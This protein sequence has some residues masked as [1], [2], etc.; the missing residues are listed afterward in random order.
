MRK[1][2]VGWVAVAAWVLAGTGAVQAHPPGAGAGLT[3]PPYVHPDWPRP[4][5]RPPIYPPWHH[6]PRPP[7]PGPRPSCRNSSRGGPAGPSPA[8]ASR[9]PQR[10]P[11]ALVT[12]PGHVPASA[13]RPG[14]LQLA[15][16][17]SLILAFPK[18][19]V[20]PPL[21]GLMNAS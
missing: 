17:G 13:P 15:G 14:V 9:R 2:F 19:W 21:F 11:G 4:W 7:W 18:P 8:G 1:L 16:A 12:S 10:G 5:P 3:L 6:P 20:V